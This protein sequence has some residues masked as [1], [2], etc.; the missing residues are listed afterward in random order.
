M[1][2]IQVIQMKYYKGFIILPK[3]VQEDLNRQLKNF[4]S[5]TYSCSVASFL[6]WK[7]KQHIVHGKWCMEELYF[8]NIGTVTCESQ[9]TLTPTLFLGDYLYTCFCGVLRCIPSATKYITEIV[10]SIDWKAKT[11]KNL[12]SKIN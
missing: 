10:K 7:K 5:I 4:L 3:N 2:G 12:W 1:D 6:S 11:Q 9:T 8:K